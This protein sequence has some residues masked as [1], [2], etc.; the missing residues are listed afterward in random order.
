MENQIKRIEEL[1]TNRG[2][3][4]ILE[5]A[6]WFHSIDSSSKWK[7]RLMGYFPEG[8]DW[9]PVAYDW[10]G[11]HY[12]VPAHGGNIRVYDLVEV[13]FNPLPIGFDYFLNEFPHVDANEISKGSTRRDRN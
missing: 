4:S 1:L 3:S 12:V 13:E 10:L 6:L 8:P 2:Q 7:E 9:V 11:S 5:S